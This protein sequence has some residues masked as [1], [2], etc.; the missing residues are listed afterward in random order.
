MVATPLG[1]A[2][3]SIEQ[4]VQR[5]TGAALLP[6]SSP[7]SVCSSPHSHLLR[8]PSRRWGADTLPL[9]H[10]GSGNGPPGSSASTVAGPAA[11]GLSGPI[12]ALTGP[13]SLEGGVPGPV[14][15]IGCSCLVLSVPWQPSHSLSAPLLQTAQSLLTHSSTARRG[16][17]ADERHFQAATV[18][19]GGRNT[20]E[21]VL[22]WAQSSDS[23]RTA[24]KRVRSTLA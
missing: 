17:C 4:E 12:A 24:R 20:P 13:G 5:E 10:S 14:S 23:R 19:P 8:F 22:E 3:I 7:S 2:L 21:R 9:R 15:H 1:A 18:R 11:L 6:Y 16:F